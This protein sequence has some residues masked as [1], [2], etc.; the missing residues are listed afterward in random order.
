VV[1]NWSKS[2]ELIKPYAD[3]AQSMSVDSYCFVSSAGMYKPS[4]DGPVAE[5]CAVK[6]T[7]QREA[8]E[9]LAE[10]ELPYSYFRPQYIYGPKQGKSYLS[11]F[12]Y[13]ITRGRT[14]LIPNS[15]DQFVTMTHAADNAAMIAAAVA[16]GKAAGEAFNC[17]TSK[18]ITYTELAK[19]CA[20]AA[21]V[22]AD[23]SYYEPKGL[24]IPKGFF[25]FRDTAFYV[26]VNKACDLLDFSPK[27]DLAQD[28]KWYFTD[29]YVAQGGAEKDVDFSIDE[30]ITAAVA[31]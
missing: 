26:G 29:N 30:M 27:Y 19:L 16:N 9:L 12:F 2:P 3:L 17:A 25:P 28:I 5:T 21:G 1:D 11:Y 6:S 23:I 7:G 13:R 8:E 10:M 14:I 15:G 24:E 22:E 31:A 18:L 4:G 20:D